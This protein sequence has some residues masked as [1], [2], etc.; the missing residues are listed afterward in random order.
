MTSVRHL[1]R[2]RML[3]DLGCICCRKLGYEG[4]PSDIHHVLG[5]GYKNNDRTIPLCA[6][7]HRAVEW[8][9]AHGPSLAQGSKPFEERWGSEEELLREV[10][11]AIFTLVP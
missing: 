5:H 10:D 1:K 8:T 2:Y 6:A 4:V 11:H 3:Q 7:H 9:P